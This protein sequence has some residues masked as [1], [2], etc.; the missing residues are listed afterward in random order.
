MAAEGVPE[1]EWLK[2]QKKVWFTRASGNFIRSLLDG[3]TSVLRRAVW[4]PWTMLLSIFTKE[5][6]LS[7]CAKS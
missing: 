5:A 3:S 2:L 4:R 1:A 6:T 7:T